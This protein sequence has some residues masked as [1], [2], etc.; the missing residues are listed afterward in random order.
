MAYHNTLNE[1]PFSSLSDYALINLLASSKKKILEILSE[2][3]IS[4][5]LRSRLNPTEYQ[6][7][8]DCNCQY[9]DIDQYNQIP[10]NHSFGLSLY[11]QNIRS[12]SKNY[13]QLV[14][15][16]LSIDHDFD[17]IMLT[18]IGKYNISVMGHILKSVFPDHNFYYRTPPTNPRGGVAVLVKSIIGSKYLEIRPELDLMMECNCDKCQVESLFIDINMDERYTIGCIYRHPNGNCQHFS[19]ALKHS[20]NKIKHKGPII[21]SGDINI[22]LIK[23]SN[24]Q[25]KDYIETLGELQ[26]I[27]LT[28]IPTR[29]T[30]ETATC[31]DHFYVKP[32][33]KI[34]S[35]SMK[36]GALFFRRQ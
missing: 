26:L 3:E 13:G 19:N 18:E 28:T 23:N 6:T 15:F 8:E 34:C 33:K 29:I 21:L 22:D 25:V 7:L 2:M 30:D 36:T 35:K 11:H 14:A 32:S 27:P 1:L 17:I 24:K 10:F 12:L 4:Q 16:L 5:F 31:I 20:I 9:Y